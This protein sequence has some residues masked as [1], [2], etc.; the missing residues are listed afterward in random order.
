MEITP[1]HKDVIYAK[2]CPY[3]KS[4]TKTISESDV[5]GREYK[6]RKIIA[7]VNFPRCDSYVGTHDNGE[8]LGRLANKALRAAKKNAHYWFDKIWKEKFAERS[9]LYMYLSDYLEL[10]GEYTHIG[11]FSLSTCNKVAEWPKE[12]YK[13]IQTA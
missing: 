7:C 12:R 8:A 6:G 5:Y 2:I 3:C 4:K 1:Y 9:E 13:E 11:M 10:P